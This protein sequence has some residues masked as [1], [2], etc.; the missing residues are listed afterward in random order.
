MS[1]QFNF[2]TFADAQG[3]DFREYLSLVV[4]KLPKADERYQ[5]TC[6]RISA[7]Y[8]QYP[9]M[10]DVF[11]REDVSALTEQKCGA[12]IEIASLRVLV[13]HVLSP[14]YGLI[15][16]DYRGGSWSGYATF[17]KPSA[18]WSCDMRL[19]FAKG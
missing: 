9:R 11:D 3:V 19:K 17:G 14:P 1:E 16:S 8:E 12:M 15:C 10:M 18:C 4:A 2:E 7:I 13:C 5:A 6:D